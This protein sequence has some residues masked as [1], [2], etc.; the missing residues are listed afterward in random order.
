MYPKTKDPSK[1]PEIIPTAGL[2]MSYHQCRGK[3]VKDGYCR[4]HHP[5]AVKARREEAMRKY[6]EKLAASPERRLR[7]AMGCITDLER[8]L[9][10]ALEALEIARVGMCAVGVP[11][12]EERAVLNDAYD[13]VNDTIKQLTPQ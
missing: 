6:E 12:D 1:C 3:V 5:D 7:D 11:N 13:K 10:L 9:T 2:R 8:K 4:V